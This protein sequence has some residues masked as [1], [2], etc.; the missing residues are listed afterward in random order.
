M[1][2]QSKI[3]IQNLKNLEKC[4]QHSTEIDFSNKDTLKTRV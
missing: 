2:T 1:K 4:F 3:Q